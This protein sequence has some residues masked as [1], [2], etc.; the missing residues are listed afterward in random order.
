LIARYISDRKSEVSAAHKGGG[1]FKRILY[2][3]Q[4]CKL[5]HVL[6]PANFSL[7]NRHRAKRKDRK[8]PYLF[9]HPIFLPRILYNAEKWL[10]ETRTTLPK[11]VLKKEKKRV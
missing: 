2:A 5:R 11:W 6:D 1:A 8:P 4:S 7:I 3:M 10:T 9:A